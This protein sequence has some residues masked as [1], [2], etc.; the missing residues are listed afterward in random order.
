MRVSSCK[1]H[2]GSWEP[3][4]NFICLG[5]AFHWGWRKKSA[6]FL[7]RERISEVQSTLQTN[8]TRNTWRVFCMLLHDDA[9]R[10]V[11]HGR[12]RAPIASSCSWKGLEGS[13]ET[14]GGTLEAACASTPPSQ[15]QLLFTT[16]WTYSPCITHIL[17]HGL[18]RGDLPSGDG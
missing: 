13:A 7:G 11:S 16:L 18:L 8:L 3:H 1:S 5:K 10:I 14:C 15:R 9:R 12:L 2:L 6:Y 17:I 4:F